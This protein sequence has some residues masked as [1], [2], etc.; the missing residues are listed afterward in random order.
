MTTLTTVVKTKATRRLK[1]YLLSSKASR[2]L[3][4]TTYLGTIR[5][6]GGTGPIEKKVMV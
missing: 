2:P 4:Q 5:N 1:Q 6:T 3:L